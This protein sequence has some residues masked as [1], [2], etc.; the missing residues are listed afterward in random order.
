MS[1]FKSIMETVCDK[2]FGTIGYS[3]SEWYVPNTNTMNYTVQ[4]QGETKQITIHGIADIEYYG[5]SVGAVMR[6]ELDKEFP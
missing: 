4:Y 5:G 6:S 1:I 2:K 3:I